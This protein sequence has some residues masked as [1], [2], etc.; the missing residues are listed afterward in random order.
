MVLQDTWLFA[1]TIR[2]NIAYGRDGRDRGGGRGRRHEAAHV[3][4]FVRALPDGYETVLDDEAS[5]LSAG[6][7]S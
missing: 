6:S 5:N 3:D 4:H 1:G 7:G 2:D